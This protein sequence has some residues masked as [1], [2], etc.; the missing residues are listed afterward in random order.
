MNLAYIFTADLQDQ[1][2]PE[3]DPGAHPEEYEE[4]P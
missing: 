2:D 4:V 3:I 1:L